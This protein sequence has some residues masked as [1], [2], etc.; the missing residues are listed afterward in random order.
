[1]RTSACPIPFFTSIGLLYLHRGPSIP[2]QFAI[3][4]VEETSMTYGIT[5]QIPP[6]A[7]PGTRSSH[8]NRAFNAA[9][10]EL[11]A[12]DDGKR[13]AR[14]YE[15]YMNIAPR[16]VPSGGDCDRWSDV[17]TDDAAL[18]RML[19]SGKVRFGYCAGE[20]YVWIVDGVRT[21]F[22]FDLGTAVVRNLSTHFFSD[23]NQ[24]AA[25]WIE[26]QVSGDDQAD[27]LTSLHKGLVDNTFDVALSGQMMLPT[28]YLGGLA[29]E[30]T[31][32]T[33][34]LFTAISYTGRQRSVID[35]QKLEDMRSSDLPTFKAFAIDES[36]RLNLEF[37][38]FSVV[39]PGPSPKAAQDLVYAINHGGG[40]SVWDCGDIVDSNAVMWQAT[41]HFAVGDS[42]AS[43][44]QTK[45]EAFKGIY[46]NIP[47]TDELWPIAG[48]T[49]GTEAATQ[50]EIAV[51]AE[52]SDSY[53]PMVTDPTLPP[54]QQGWNIRVFNRTEVRRA[55]AIHLEQGTG[56]VTLG[57][58]L[59]HINA[60]SIVT[61]DGVL[62]PGT[63]GPY[64]APYVGY[65][66]LRYVDTPA[67]PNEDAIAIGT[68]STA[69]M[70]AST[71]DTWLEVKET[72][73]IVLEHQV[74][75]DVRNLY[76]QGLWEGSSWH[77][78]ARIGIQRLN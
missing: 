8:I 52:H 71:I 15:S 42:L 66:R 13:Y 58:G 77:V 47:A 24:L 78:F 61:Y 6:L 69:D 62:K 1:M 16:F 23:P 27:K 30:W 4:P 45:N 18:K 51:Y 41:D 63:T 38:I 9:L 68:M 56:V 40:R 14:L 34:M 72:A 50:P 59:Y 64:V 39:N 19:A 10:G 28:A 35:V 76:L 17:D 7:P 44:A 74:G 12:E 67:C 73:R 31:S 2:P 75:N 60:I 26:V 53:K 11:L 36:D 57:P 48:F 29:I 32:P 33:A 3:V 43:G 5:T 37:R 25:D 46:L 49:A 54:L 70:G 65:C 21:G 55:N 20:P 22:D